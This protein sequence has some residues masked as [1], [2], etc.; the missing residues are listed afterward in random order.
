MGV[1]THLAIEL[2]LDV[3]GDVLS[4]EPLEPMSSISKMQKR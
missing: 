2:W 3:L 1:D 4:A